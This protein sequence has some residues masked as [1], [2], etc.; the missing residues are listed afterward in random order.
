MSS[1]DSV[2]LW[3]QKDL[4]FSRP[5]IYLES[6]FNLGSNSPAWHLPQIEP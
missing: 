2:S 5:D 6:V 4:D 1:F 3:L